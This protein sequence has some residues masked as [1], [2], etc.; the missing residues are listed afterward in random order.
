MKAFTV[1]LPSGQAVHYVDR[2]RWW[3]ALALVFPLQPFAG[4]WLHAQ[5]GHDAWLAAGFVLTFAIGPLADALL[6]EDRNNP[7]QPVV[8]LLEQ[9]RWYRWLTWAAV[10]VHVVTLVGCLAYATTADVGAGGFFA[11]ALGAGMAAGLAINT[12]HEL[13]HR[14]SRLE[15]TLAKIALAVPAYGH[16]S[17]DHNRGHHRDVATPDDPASARMGEN[18]Y[19]FARREIPGAVL[20]AWRLERER[21]GNRGRPA[22]HRSNQLLQAWL[23]AAGIAAAL[24]FAFGWLALPFLLLHHAAAYFQLTSANYIEH[25]GLLRERGPDG[26]HE[27]CAP[28]HSWNSNHVL[29]NLALFHLERHSDHHV[30]PLR[31]YQSLRHLDD[32]PRL[33]SGYFGMYLLAWVPPLWFRVMD[34][35]LLALP[36]VH[37][38]LGRVNLCPRA[39][40]RLHDRYA[41][42]AGAATGSGPG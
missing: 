24:V 29:S 13:G 33:P 41:R 17:L 36:H 4:I 19:R 40:G 26:R 27:R 35:R 16:F 15:R 31:R 37:G 9:D 39:A 2:K 34:P 3:W 42:S 20:R 23:L 14:N 11:L 22:W 21:L 38:D 6:G 30:H 32:A 8:P 28:R 25:Y 1:T 10:P 7:P 18:I 12:G 5:T